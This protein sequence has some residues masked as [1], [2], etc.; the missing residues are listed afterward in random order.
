VTELQTLIHLQE[1]DS[2]IAGLEAEAARLPRQIEALQ[3][4]LAE[5]RK[6]MDTTRARLDT[7]R[8]ELRAREKDLD[9]LGVKRT[10]SEGRLYEVKTNVEYSAVLTEIETIKAQKGQA[11]EEILALM[12]RQESLAGEIREAE[13][14]LKAREDQAR[15]EEAAIRDKLGQV[16]AEL[17]RVRAERVTVAR[18][19]P[20]TTLSDYERIMK[21]RGGLGVAAVTTAGVC[22]GCRVTIRPQAL[23]ELRSGGFHH[24]ESCGRFLYWQEQT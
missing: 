10:R 12:E 5:A 9:D 17:E 4:S 2:R 13:G 23:V 7:A 16:Q 6:V 18:E 19:L 8:K 24:C 11:E 3:A 1:Y 14:R 22:G 20:R 21:A 15:Q